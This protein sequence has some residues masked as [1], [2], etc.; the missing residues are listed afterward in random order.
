MNSG[1]Y[2]LALRP[3]GKILAVGYTSSDGLVYRLGLDGSPDQTFGQGGTVALD[4]GDN[5]RTYA[6]ALQPGDGKILV[7]GETYS[8]GGAKKDLVVYRLTR[9]GEP[10]AGFG[11]D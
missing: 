10:D 1:A 9:G 5:E 7:A 3:D 4:S 2:G 8:N 11:T 6:L